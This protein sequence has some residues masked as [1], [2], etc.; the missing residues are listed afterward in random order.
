VYPRAEQPNQP[1]VVV[2]EPNFRVVHVAAGPPAPVPKEA[3]PG[4]IDEF[5]AAMLEEIHGCGR[6]Y[7]TLHANYW[8]SGQV[9]H[10]LKHELS[11]PMVA[12]FHTLGLVKGPGESAARVQGETDI[13]RCAD[14]ILAATREEAG[15][16]D[17]LYGADPERI[18][19]L[20]PGVDHQ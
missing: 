7:E 1:R 13:I 12:T 3:L 17:R 6:R 4:L 14:L 16:L 20:P 2:V 9:A 10:G 15:Q 18:E 19:V 11:L 8:L 5:K